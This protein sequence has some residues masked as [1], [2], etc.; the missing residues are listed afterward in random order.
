MQD[1]GPTAFY[2]I[3]A[4]LIPLFLLGGVIV[5][6]AKAPPADYE[7]DTNESLD[8][9]GT[10][11]KRQLKH[12]G[13]ALYLPV[14]GVYVILVEIVA[15]DAVA[16]GK[17]DWTRALIV[18]GTLIFAML[19][20]VF[21]V[22]LPWAKHLYSKAQAFWSFGF[23]IAFLVAYLLIGQFP[24]PKFLPFFEDIA[25]EPA[26]HQ[27]VHE[28]VWLQHLVATSDYRIAKL[29][30]EAAMGGTAAERAGPRIHIQHVVRT[31]QC[32][33]LEE[34]LNEDPSSEPSATPSVVCHVRH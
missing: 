11:L 7:S 23:A 18:G 33:A 16:S 26:H 34:L 19:S 5:E 17:S 8:E 4:T 9:W 30:A 25:T 28:E 27:R 10:R 6:A 32:D 2:G 14:I 1:A 31:Q 15:L 20:V 13:I 22:W 21:A 12:Q 3:A 24:G 29:E